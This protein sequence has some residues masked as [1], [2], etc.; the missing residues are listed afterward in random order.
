MIISGVPADAYTML[1]AF[2]EADEIAGPTFT[3]PLRTSNLPFSVRSAA[4]AP[5]TILKDPPLAERQA[6]LGMV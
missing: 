5:V 1:N 4:A 3:V 6:V 2:A